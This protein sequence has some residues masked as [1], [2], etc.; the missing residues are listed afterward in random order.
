MEI[1]THREHVNTEAETEVMA[2]DGE[3]KE[4]FLTILRGQKLWKGIAKQEKNEVKSLV[5]IEAKLPNK[6]LLKII[7]EEYRTII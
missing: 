2:L 1:C 3:K 6:I 5:N 4:H 7:Q